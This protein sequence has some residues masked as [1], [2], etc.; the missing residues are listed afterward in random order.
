MSVCSLDNSSTGVVGSSSGCTSSAVHAACN[1]IFA[2]EDGAQR[3]RYSVETV[4]L[5]WLGW[6]F[7]FYQGN[8]NSLASVDLNAGY[9]GVQSFRLGFAAALVTIN[10]YGAVLLAAALFVYR[11]AGTDCDRS[12]LNV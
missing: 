5:L 11:L 7:F 9:V 4:A 2:A 8:S 1:R 6:A 12:A 10:T 3:V